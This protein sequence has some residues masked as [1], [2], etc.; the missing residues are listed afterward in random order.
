MGSAANGQAIDRQEEARLLRVVFD[1][2]RAAAE[3]AGGDP[4]PA[5]V[6][7]AELEALVSADHDARSTIVA[8]HQGFVAMV[9]RRY[10]TGR[11][12]V[13][14][15]IQEGN[16]GLLAALD[17][18]DPGVGVRFN[19]FAFYWIRQT[20]IAALP[21]HQ[22][23]LAVSRSVVR[24][25]NRVR[26]TRA[27]VER[28]LGCG[29]TAE[30]VAR[31]AGLSVRRVLELENLGVGLVPLNED[32]ARDIVDLLDD[33]DPAAR[34][35]DDGPVVRGL[36]DRLAAPERAV[37]TCR[38]GFGTAPQYQSQIAETLGVT[39]SRV[40]QIQRKALDDLRRLART[41]LSAA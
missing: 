34:D 23:G 38:Y 33:G 26:K 40:S 35:D 32:I 31:A 18:F 20:I 36:L 41:A 39:V 21:R 25:V 4:G 2:R 13:A 10:R 17:R 19:T 14:D 16:I 30:E 27:E 3:L 11:V 22:D 8:N 5:P 12:P 29:A 6:R 9:A 28:A 1:G 7:R 37:I 15:L 24:E